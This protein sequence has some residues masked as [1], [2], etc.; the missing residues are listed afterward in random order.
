MNDE[1]KTRFIN[2]AKKHFDNGNI[3]IV[4]DVKEGN[5]E[6]FS[7]VIDRQ[8]YFNCMSFLNHGWGNGYVGILISNE[9]NDIRQKII[10]SI[11]KIV[12]EQEITYNEFPVI[13]FDTA[14]FYNSSRHDKDYVVSEANKMLE[15]IKE[16]INELL[17]R[18]GK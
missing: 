9:L 4:K 10:D 13:G 15:L 17:K 12:F 7:F 6:I 5:I 2:E 14:H 16:K 11:D 1:T 3:E 18:E 8:D